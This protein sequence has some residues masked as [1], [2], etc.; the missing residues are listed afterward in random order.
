MKK[1]LIALTLALCILSAH[2]QASQVRSMSVAYPNGSYALAIP[3]YTNA[4]SLAA[5]TAE[6][7]TVP[8][9]ANGSKA[10]Y[11]SF[12]STCDFYANYRTTATV[13]GD[14]TDGSASELNPLIRLV[15]TSTTTISVISASTCIITASFYM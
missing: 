8:T 14:T 6:S 3:D 7:F 11:V 15:D 13:P 5:S 1:I 2:A 9:G 12:A 4:L 10:R